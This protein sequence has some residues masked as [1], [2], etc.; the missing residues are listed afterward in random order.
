MLLIMNQNTIKHHSNLFQ[1]KWPS[2]NLT[3]MC[4]CIFSNNKLILLYSKKYVC[5]PQQRLF[6][7][8]FM[9]FKWLK[10]LVPNFLCLTNAYACLKELLGY[11]NLLS[12]LSVIDLRPDLTY[13]SKIS[14][15]VNK[16]SYNWFRYQ[17]IAMLK[18]NFLMQI[19]KVIT[20]FFLQVGSSSS[21]IW[22]Q[23]K[24]LFSY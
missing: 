24:H 9:P 13:P 14:F 10:S 2:W 22:N 12:T 15:P 4:I 5:R 18:I 3:V 19:L 20:P 16:K 8:A 1:S 21:F 17:A 7:I 23:I 6:S 11:C